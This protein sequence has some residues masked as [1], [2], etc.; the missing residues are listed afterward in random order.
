MKQQEVRDW[1][2]EHYPDIWAEMEKMGIRRRNRDGLMTVKMDR[3]L[4]P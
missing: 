1:I 3:T 4:K 2:Q